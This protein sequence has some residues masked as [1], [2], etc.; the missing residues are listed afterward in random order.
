MKDPAALWN[1]DSEQR[2]VLFDSMVKQMQQNCLSDNRLSAVTCPEAKR[3]PDLAK[4]LPAPPVAQQPAPAEK[5]ING[6]AA[7]ID[8]ILAGAGSPGNT[9]QM[10]DVC[11]QSGS[12]S[13]MHTPHATCSRD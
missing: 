8:G 13:H 2:A 3:D 9:V 11:I 10:Q 7:K 5:P 6:V 1:A 12:T 4:K